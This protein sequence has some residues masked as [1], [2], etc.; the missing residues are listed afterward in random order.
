[1]KILIRCICLFSDIIKDLEILNKDYSLGEKNRKIF[2]VLSKYWET[3]ATAIEE[4]K[5]LNSMPI[6][7][8]VNL[9]TSYELKLKSKAQEEEEVRAKKSVT[10]RFIKK[11]RIHSPLMLKMKRWKK[12]S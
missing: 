1:M 4:A 3:K 2:N 8:L 10:L 5:D 9:L 11:K 6:E 12:M 7:T